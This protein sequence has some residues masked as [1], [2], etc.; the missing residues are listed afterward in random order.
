MC[1]GNGFEVFLALVLDFFPPKNRKRS[2]KR[3]RHAPTDARNCK[4]L[5]SF[6]HGGLAPNIDTL[7]RKIPAIVPRFVCLDCAS[8]DSRE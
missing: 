6:S 5:M 3:K 1:R 4:S 8:R 7:C 2:F